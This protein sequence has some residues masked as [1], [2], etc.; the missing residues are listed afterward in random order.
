ML[1]SFFDLYYGHGLNSL[2]SFFEITPL[3]FVSI[4]LKKD[5]LKFSSSKNIYKFT[6]NFNKG[7]DGKCIK[8][9]ASDNDSVSYSHLDIMIILKLKLC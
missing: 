9:N 3:P 7:G 8:C 5:L 2:S 4:I 1:L 6:D